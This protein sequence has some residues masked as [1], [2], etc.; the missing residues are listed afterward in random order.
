MNDPTRIMI[1]FAIITISD[2]SAAGKR[3]DLS[4]PALQAEI[5]RNGWLVGFTKTIPDDFVIIKN[6][7]LEITSRNN[8]DVILTTGGTGFS[9]RDVTPE[10]TREV[11]LK[12]A[13]GL[14]EL[15]RFESGRINPNAFLSRGIAGI[16]GKTIIINLPG[17]PKGAVENFN[18][19]CPVLSHAV[20]LMTGKTTSH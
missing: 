11:I 9:E 2:S 3:T 7:L 20:A 18:A 12:E 8:L 13:T 6:L 10:A 19:V 4:G 14:A 5:T 16:R 17:S 15:M 1:N